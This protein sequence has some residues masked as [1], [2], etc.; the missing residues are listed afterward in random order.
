MEARG[1]SPGT[2]ENLSSYAGNFGCNLPRVRAWVCVRS[3]LSMNRSRGGARER[4]N[5]VMEYE[6][7]RPSTEINP[8]GA[9]DLPSVYVVFA[10]PSAKS[11]NF[12][13]AP[14]R[15]SINPACI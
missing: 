15:R 11:W 13:C 1:S 7:A 10:A 3:R 4:A 8:F 12:L 2:R 5:A 9:N 14:P 6:V